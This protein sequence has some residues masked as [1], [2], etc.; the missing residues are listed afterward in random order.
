MYVSTLRDFIQAVGGTLEI[1]ASFS[2]RP[3][4]KIT[5]FE[6]LTDDQ[7]ADEA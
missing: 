2:N 6:V 5:Q 7:K 4:V 3:P 1:T